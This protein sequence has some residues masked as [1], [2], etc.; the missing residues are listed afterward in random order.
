MLLL[1]LGLQEANVDGTVSKAL[2]GTGK[3]EGRSLRRAIAAVRLRKCGALAPLVL[4]FFQKWKRR[5]GVEWP[6][7]HMEGSGVEL[8]KMYEDHAK[9]LVAL[10]FPPEPLPPMLVLAAEVRH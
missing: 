5:L 3:I 2:V 6:V 10:A 8:G 4:A 1:V 7:A 9:L